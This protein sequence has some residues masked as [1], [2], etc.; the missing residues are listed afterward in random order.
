MSPM[1][2]RVNE[3]VSR[4]DGA[5]HCAHCGFAL[6]GDADTYLQ[7]LAQA[8]GPVSQVG[9]HVFA[10]AGVY[11][12]TGVVF[13]QFYCPGCFTAFHTEVVPVDHATWLAGGSA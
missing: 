9:P 5:L 12:D 11:I 7:H 2:S 13:R 6:Q 10:D 8:E 3:N 1:S 4:R